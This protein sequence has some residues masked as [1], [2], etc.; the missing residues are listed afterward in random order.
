MNAQRHI[1]LLEETL[2]EHRISYRKDFLLKFETYFKTGGIAKLYVNPI[3][4]S[5]LKA[6]VQ[7]ARTHGIPFKIIGLTTN[8]FFLDELEYGVIISTKGMTGLQIKENTISVECGYS[9]QELVRVALINGMQGLEG[10]EGIPG[11]V[12]G[13]VFM[14]AGAY[15]YSISDHL[16]SVDYIDE[17]GNMGS[18]L[19]SECSF[20]LRTSIF[21][22]NPE[23][24]IT[25]ANLKLKPGKRED[26]AH[27]IETYHIARHS[28]QDFSYPNL[29]SMFSINGDFYREL[30]KRDALY[31]SICYLLKLIFKNPLSKFLSRKRPNN[32]IFNKLA[33]T[34][35]ALDTLTYKP[36]LKS[37]NIL[38]NDG[39]T[40]SIDLIEYINEIRKRL[41]KEIS[42][43]N[44]IVTSPINMNNK[45]SNII[46]N[47]ISEKGLL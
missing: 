30:F 19:A 21:R 6:V 23:Y 42:L 8:I 9:L 20:T 3:N 38:V 31:R 25:S 10:L 35:A 18:L 28:Y 17:S 41:D 40:R 43:E 46:L 39:N 26:I 27:R 16:V 13:A 24:I 34:Y 7:A 12:G 22:K 4:T 47:K 5:E 11:T 14:N 2:N 32:K 37:M 15:G 29:G 45:E 1:P 33:I 44:E 36:S